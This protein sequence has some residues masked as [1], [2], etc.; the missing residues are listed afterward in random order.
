MSLGNWAWYPCPAIQ[1]ILLEVTDPDH[2]WTFQPPVRPTLPVL[3]LFCFVP[4][5]SQLGRQAA[6]PFT[7]SLASR[8]I[9]PPHLLLPSRS[10]CTQRVALNWFTVWL[11]F[12]TCMAFCT[13]EC[14]CNSERRAESS[15][16]ACKFLVL[17]SQLAL[18]QRSKVGLAQHLWQ[19][20]HLFLRRQTPELSYYP[21]YVN[22]SKDLY[23][24]G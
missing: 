4:K 1:V 8:F 16:R 11:T 3:L 5:T 19:D 15:Q 24:H 18:N 22:L 21:Q 9:P 2:S 7:S 23:T 17:I 13:R 14:M 12:A 6:V 20:K 10:E